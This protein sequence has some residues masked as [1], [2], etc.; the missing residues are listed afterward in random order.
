MIN[1][2]QFVKQDANEISRYW[3]RGK[4]YE[5]SWLLELIDAY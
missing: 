3:A 1:G 2:E 5:Q 4:L